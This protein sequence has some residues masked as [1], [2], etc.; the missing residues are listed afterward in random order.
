MAS[1]SLKIFLVDLGS[2]KTCQ[3]PSDMYVIEICKDIRSKYNY[4]EGGMGHGLLLKESGTWLAPNKMLGHYELKY[5]DTL[6]FRKKHRVLKVKT[7]DENVKNILIDES[8]NVKAIVEVICDKIGLANH[9]EYSLSR[10]E[11]VEVTKKDKKKKDNTTDAKGWLIAD[12]T[13]RDQGLTEEDAV[14]LKKKFFVTDHV[15]DR[16]D[17]IQLVLMYNQARE[18]ILNGKYPCTFEEAAQFGG[19][20]MQIKYGNQDPE[21][22][23]L[24]FIKMKDF[25]GPEYQKNKDLEKLIY[26][27]HSMLKGT[28]EL[29]AKFRYVQLIRSLKIYGTSFFLVKELADKAKKKKQE[30][31]FLGV[32]KNSVV[33]MNMDTKAIMQEWKLTQLRRWAATP[34]NFTLDFGDHADSYYQVETTEGEEISRLIAGYIA[35]SI[36]KRTQLATAAPPPKM[37]EQA[38]VEDYVTP[39]KSNNVA[40]VASRAVAKQ[41]SSNAGPKGGYGADQGKKTKGQIAED[42]E[43]L[44]NQEIIIEQIKAA[45][46]QLSASSRDLLV[47]IPLP[48]TSNDPSAIAWRD[49]M[50]DINSEALASLISGILASIAALLLEADGDK[51]KMNYPLIGQKISMILSSSGQATQ[52][53]RVLCGLNTNDDEAQDDLINAGKAMVDALCGFLNEV[54]PIITGHLTLTDMHSSASKVAITASSL[55]SKIDHLDVSDL[56]QSELIGAV[57][58]VGQALAALTVAGQAVGKSLTDNDMKKKMSNELTTISGTGGILSTCTAVMAPCIADPICKEQMV[59]TAIL[60]RDRAVALEN[61]CVHCPDQELAEALQKAVADTEDA[62]AYLVEKARNIDHSLD[63]EIETYHDQIELES[64][65]V[66]EKIDNREELFASAKGLTV[67]GTRLV[68]VL[69]LKASQLSDE[70]GGLNLQDEARMLSELI[71]AMVA[72]TR[73]VISN[74][75]SDQAKAD[76]VDVIDQIRSKNQEICG[77]FI[78]SNILRSLVQAFKGTISSSNQV[79]FTSRQTGNTNKDRNAQLNLIKS[80]KR[81]TEKIPKSVKAINAT[82]KNPFDYATR[83]KFIQTAK[84]FIVPVENLTE[85]AQT[86]STS[87]GDEFGK[88]QLQMNV[89]QLVQELEN[90]KNLLGE[91]EKMFDDE[92]L[93]A[94][95][96]SLQSR[97]QDG[98]AVQMS[99]DEAEKEVTEHARQFFNCLAQIH[100]A[101]SFQDSFG[102]RLGVTDAVT[103]LQHIQLLMNCI[104]KQ[105]DD[106]QACDDIKKSSARLG[107]ALTNL[108][109]GVASISNREIDDDEFY[110]LHDQTS[111]EMN[112]LLA[113]LPGQRAMLAVMDKIRQIT[114]Q[115][116]LTVETAN[117]TIEEKQLETPLQTATSTTAEASPTKLSNDNDTLDSHRLIVDAAAQLSIAAQALVNNSHGDTK[118]MKEKINSLEQSF[119]KL[120]DLSAALPKNEESNHVLSAVQ[121]VGLECNQFLHTLQTSYIDSEASGNRGQLVNAAKS[122]SETV[123]ELLGLF[124]I[125]KVGYDDCNKATQI[126]NDISNVISEVN[127]PRLNQV[128][129]SD[130][131]YLAQ[132]SLHRLNGHALKLCVSSGDPETISA[133]V[134]KLASAVQ[135]LIN[136]AIDGGHILGISDPTTQPAVKG[137]LHDEK[138]AIAIK[139]SRLAVRDL[140]SNYK[141]SKGTLNDVALIS[142]QCAVVCAASKAASQDPNL[143]EVLR[144]QFATL[145][146][147]LA[148]ST[149][150]VVSTMKSASP[151]RFE[152]ITV[153][154]TNILNQLNNYENLLKS[155]GLSGQSSKL[156]DKGA[157]LQLPIIESCNAMLMES[158]KIVFLVQELCS[159]PNNN[160]LKS[161][162]LKEVST[163][164]DKGKALLTLLKSSEPGLSESEAAI[165]RVRRANHAVNEKLESLLANPPNGETVVDK[166]KGD[167]LLKV[168]ETLKSLN[169]ITG[170]AFTASRGNVQTLLHYVEDFPDTFEITTKNALSAYSNVKNEDQIDF[171]ISIKT[172]GDLLEEFIRTLKT[173]ISDPNDYSHLQLE[174]QSEAI[175]KLIVSTHGKLQ[176]SI[177]SVPEFL[178]ANMKMEAIINDF[179]SNGTKTVINAPLAT[180]SASLETSTK[181]LQVE[182]EQALEAKSIEEYGPIALKITKQYEEITTNAGVLIHETDDD[183][184]KQKL[185]AMV[186]ELGGSAM[187]AI[188]TLNQTSLKGSIDAT[189]RNKLNQNIK[190]L[191][192]QKHELVALAKQSAPVVTA[193][194]KVTSDLDVMLTEFNSTIMFAE[195]RQLNPISETDSFP[196][197]K[198]A[199]LESAQTLSDVF[200]TFLNSPQLTQEAMGTLVQ[201][202][203]DAYRDLKVKSTQAAMAISSVDYEMQ[204]ELLSTAVDIGEAMKGLIEATQNSA[205]KSNDQNGLLTNKIEEQVKVVSQLVEKVNKVNDQVGISS[206]TYQNTISCIEDSDKILNDKDLPALGTSLP[207][208][209]VLLSNQLGAS[210]FTL[211]HKIGGDKPEE[212]MASL[213]QLRNAIDALYRA[214]KAAVVNAPKEK[215]ENTISSISSIGQ[216]CKQLVQAIQQAQDSNQ[217][218]NMKQYLNA[219]VKD[220]TQAIS[221]TE[222]MVSELLP[223]GYADPNDPNVIAERDLMS[224]TSS[225][226]NAAKKMAQLKPIDRVNTSAADNAF[227]D[228]VLN[229]AQNIASA[230]AILVK[231]ATAVQ[232]EVTASNHP[233]SNTFNQGI[234]TASKEI[235][236]T[237]D[238]LCDVANNYAKNES[239]I[240][241]VMV[242]AK[243]ISSATAH[244]LTASAVTTTTNETTTQMRLRAAGK[245]VLDATEN[246]VVSSRG[247]AKTSGPTNTSS[248]G[249]PVSV[250]KGKILEMEA[251]MKILRLEKELENARLELAN[252]RKQKYSDKAS[253]DIETRISNQNLAVKGTA[254]QRFQPQFSNKKLGKSESGSLNPDSLG[255]II[256]GNASI[257]RTHRGWK[258]PAPQVDSKPLQVHALGIPMAKKK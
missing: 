17:P 192:T 170:G 7:L 27:E 209:I 243:N 55:L 224:I 23:K 54:L 183:D 255:T 37:E 10:D 8:T 11:T 232:R 131:N 160:N 88:Q 123:D 225:I 35:I 211:V 236:H 241:M 90:L 42:M 38:V 19:I 187:R 112:L 67:N 60:M 137:R 190:E 204:Q 82:K 50:Q 94:A 181:Q 180:V 154:A 47:P 6:E 201:S 184:L 18:M 92:E 248:N 246:L 24:G 143:D 167:E 240:E 140:I 151:N 39:G 205:G 62:L 218:A 83:F 52:S 229:A 98:S 116:D 196:Q 28:T 71:A 21:K 222:K 86:A 155:P 85:A 233:D 99:I 105:L 81:V 216:K 163:L 53:L 188:S 36:K 223:Q 195:A 76:L 210:V 48:T 108:I 89:N 203:G 34:R 139:E 148:I 153:P 110:S 25:V 159:S 43:T 247:S 179:D 173:D 146:N 194:A 149:S 165:A 126:L 129:Y 227:Q 73:G 109:K 134:S 72:N 117:V 56:V 77:P 172:L 128:T 166:S 61:L 239:P 46:A 245:A 80:G 107:D 118:A 244:L 102:A 251:Q 49:E 141:D 185:S 68:E 250:H 74:S 40:H 169:S 65:D 152:E 258:K 256:D 252:I 214:G 114:D 130:V 156:G 33:R 26:K 106:D 100:D 161:E 4:G 145:V 70:E 101:T 58:E 228:Q 51:E 69:K 231:F 158:S 230:T 13:L 103:E 138:T 22:H 249:V 200:K 78:R 162:L 29:N 197:H 1:L 215:A 171:L 125:S 20:E 15:V 144:L 79:I 12:K 30:M 147:E 121:H 122:V 41:V 5:G 136:S 226:E 207:A 191:E 189:N 219:S 113:N 164:G 234:V 174:M 182:L 257:P 186:K 66:V 97:N 45:I 95:L 242:C 104:S 202:A 168:S 75:S 31:V 217:L 142:K 93:A 133:E 14:I 59:E 235:V 199:L 119:G 16:N 157:S 127:Q 9:E 221:V 176:E 198:D 87:I 44:E 32:T 254:Q 96:N 177:A 178:E 238:A 120:I 135:E 2:V 84:E 193:C 220:I 3:Y 212:A 64:N 57:E 175:D 111:K 208:E 213:N 206:M 124:S 237:T 115:M 150:K 63:Y 132:T 91:A 253:N